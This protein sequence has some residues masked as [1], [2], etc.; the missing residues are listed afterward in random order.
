MEGE[1]TKPKILIFGGTGYLG[2]YMVKA[3]VS[4]GH[5]TFVY[6]R[7]VTEN[8]RTS[9]LEIHKEFQELDEHEKI[10]SILKEVDVVISTI[11]YPQFL[12]QLKI[13]DAIK[14]AGNI[15]RFLPSEFGCEED[16]VMPLPPFEAYLEKKRIVRR[17]IE[18]AEIPY[19]FVSANCYGAYFVNVLRRPSEPHD[20][21]VVYGNGEA[22]VVFNYEEDIANCTIKVINDP[23]TC[24]RIVIY[25]P[26]TNIISQLELISVWEQKTGRSF[27]RVH[28]SEEEPVNL[29]QTLPPPEDIP[30]SIIHSILAKGDL[31]NFELGE[32]GIEASKLYPDFKFTTIDQLLDIFLINPPKPA[33]TAFE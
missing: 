23:R 7:P 33:R 20:D 3:S 5:N 8:S 17:A 15:K 26:Q 22:K 11:A 30:T 24:N 10:I 19:T 14:V 12:D 1:N 9:K 6:A 27:K 4:S 28:V 29:S 18:A 21:V 13:V 32:D 16:R 2:K 31:M 25:R